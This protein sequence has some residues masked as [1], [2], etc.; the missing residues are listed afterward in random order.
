MPC[1]SLTGVDTSAPRALTWLCDQ[2]LRNTRAERLPG[3]GLPRTIKQHSSGQELREM[4][5]QIAHHERSIANATT[6][7]QSRLSKQTAEFC[8]RRDRYRA[9]VFGI[10]KGPA[11]ARPSSRRGGQR[12][13]S[14][15]GDGR[16]AR[17]YL[18]STPSSAELARQFDDRRARE[19][20]RQTR[21]A[22]SA[23]PRLDGGRGGFGYESAKQRLEF[24]RKTNKDAAE[25]LCSK[26]LKWWEP[27]EDDDTEQLLIQQWQQQQEQRRAPSSRP[28]SARP[29]SRPVSA[30]AKL[31]VYLPSSDSSSDR[32]TPPPLG[33]GEAFVVKTKGA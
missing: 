29:G 27:E 20:A 16:D 1:G 13:R 25:A 32:S 15:G 7:I 19:Q 4:A 22:Q 14:S 23:S 5:H 26:K 6:H 18:A 17:E 8:E 21:R 33:P 11:G 10:S 31:D 3:L 12:P 24:Y 2:Q 30:S 9:N 28:A